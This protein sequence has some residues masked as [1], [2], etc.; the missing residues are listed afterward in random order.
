ML[1]GARVAPG[2]EH[3]LEDVDIEMDL[4]WDTP[5]PPLG[6]GGGFY[7]WMAGEAAA[8]K[9]LRRF[10]VHDYGV[11]RARVSFLGY[12]RAGRPELE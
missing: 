8:V 12:W 1:A 7:A 2:I 4:L 11:D 9:S 3:A 5:E 6:A 10:L